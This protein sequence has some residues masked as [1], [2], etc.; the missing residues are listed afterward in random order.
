MGIQ[1]TMLFHGAHLRKGRFSETGRVY[2]VTSV[3]VVRLPHFRDMDA[4]RCVVRELRDTAHLG[5]ADTLAYVVMPDHLHWL[6]SLRDVA[7]P[8]LLNRI[9]SKSAIAVNARCGTRG[10]VWQRGFHDHALHRDEDVAALARYVVANPLRAG[11]VKR[12]G[13]YPLWDAVWL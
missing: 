9:K 10:P 1:R 12:V 8:A 6:V 5:L 2:L 7:L 13:D 11:L 3:T 4:G